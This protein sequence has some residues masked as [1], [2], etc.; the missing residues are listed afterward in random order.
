M[1][2]IATGITPAMCMR[3][4]N[5]GS[6]YLA[7]GVD[8]NGEPFDGSRTYRMVL[9]AAIPAA[10]FWSTTVYD[11]QSRSMLQ[12]PQRYP[13]A[14]SQAY[15]TPAAVCEADGSTIIHFGPV[16]PSGV[17]DGNWIQT[18]P[19]LGWFQILR[20]YSPTQTF[21]DKTWRAGEV[22]KLD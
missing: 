20:F 5:V 6:Q 8:A 17:S 18:D 16:Q 14:G 12:T 11:N 9:P 19:D 22:E 21:F 4:T 2:Y 7:S 13:R 15:P 3:L 10:R 1:F